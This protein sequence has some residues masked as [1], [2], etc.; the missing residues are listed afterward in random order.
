MLSS[1]RRWRSRADA[2]LVTA[3]LDPDSRAYWIERAGGQ[4]RVDH[5]NTL[6]RGM[7]L[8]IPRSTSPAADL[9]ALPAD[10]CIAAFHT[11]F[12]ALAREL[13]AKGWQFFQSAT[14]PGVKD[15]WLFAH[16]RQLAGTSRAN[17]RDV[18][19]RGPLAE[20]TARM[21]DWFAEVLGPIAARD[22]E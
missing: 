15:L 4:D 20:W 19:K 13:A 2:R 16:H 8:P 5:Y 12:A 6:D 22:P 3:T 11:H 1:L 14:R 17:A 10:A 7:P 9:S 21:E 18:Y